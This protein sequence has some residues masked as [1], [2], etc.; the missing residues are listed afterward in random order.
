MT[1]PAIDQVKNNLRTIIG[2]VAMLRNAAGAGRAFELYVM[3]GIGRALK[4]RGY[5]VWVQR[6][7][8]SRVHPT[9]SDRRFIQRGGA[10]TGIAARAQGP[11]NASSIAFRR[12]LRSTWELHNGIQFKGRSAALHEIDLAIL[13]ES[14]ARTLR[15]SSNGGRP[16]G[17]P[18]VCIECKDVGIN[19][20]VDEMRAF[21]ARLYDLTILRAHH[22]HLEVAGAA[23]RVIHPGAP[24]EGIH[25]PTVTYW[26]ENRRTLNV[27]ARRTGFVRGSAALSGYFAVEPHAGIVVGSNSATELV[28]RIA[29]WIDAHKY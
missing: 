10:P 12:D 3:T 14:V 9:D 27:L 15:N 18:R 20:S 13:P 4:A 2:N 28:D 19:G 23:P 11:D 16:L 17:R 7:D 25:C 5:D 1:A 22:R 24:A 21:V 6:S 26:N 8:G 29:D